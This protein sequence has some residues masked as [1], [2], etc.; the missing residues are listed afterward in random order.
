MERDSL[1]FSSTRHE[2]RDSCTP[3]C[4][5]YESVDEQLAKSVHYLWVFGWQVDP[6][7]TELW[8]EDSGRGGLC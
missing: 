7:P 4:T 3:T 5:G 8:G 1:D 2:I 6:A